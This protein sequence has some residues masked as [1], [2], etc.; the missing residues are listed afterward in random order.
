[1]TTS[2][3]IEQSSAV[4]TRAYLVDVYETVLTCDFGAHATELPALAG[5]SLEA[6]RAAMGKVNDPV[7]DGRLSMAEAMAEILASCG[8]NPDPGLVADLVRR[9]Q[10]LLIE[11]S[12]LHDDAVPFLEQ[13]R[14]RGISIALVS[15]C[16]ENTRPLLDAVGL[17]TLVDAIVLSCEAGHAKPSAA[18][19]HRALEQLC[20]KPDAA[21][22]VDD[23]AAYCAGAVAVGM[24]AVQV[25]REHPHLG[26]APEGTLCVNSLSEIPLML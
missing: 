14:S 10:E 23:Q 25:T 18:I 19:Y 6:Y 9:D 8:R 12:R 17:S 22:F 26:P 7:T 4:A 24:R 2:A 20:V 11:H 5:V 16:D 1:M 3:L 15:N 21:V 13:A